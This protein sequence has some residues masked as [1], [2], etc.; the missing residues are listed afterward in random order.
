MFVRRRSRR[1]GPESA[2]RPATRAPGVQ[3]WGVRR[4]SIRLVV[5]V[6]IEHRNPNAV[7]TRGLDRFWISGIRVARDAD[8][9]IARQDAFELRVRFPRA[10]RDDHHSRVQGIADADAA[11]VMHRYPRRA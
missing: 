3:V 8:S 9:R 1:A 5:I 6:L 11:A 2:T 7:T 10:V 4:S